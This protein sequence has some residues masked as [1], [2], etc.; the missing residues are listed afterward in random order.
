M[1]LSKAALRQEMHAR[2]EP[3]SVPERVAAATALALHADALL[4]LV[5]ASGRPVVSSYRAIGPELDPKLLEAALAVRGAQLC[6]PVMVGRSRPLL[7][8]RYADGDALVARTWGIQEPADTAAV[9]TP[10]I[11]LV[12]LLAVDG[13]G[14]RLGY[15]GGFYDRT[16]RD[17]RRN[18]RVVAVG[19]AY[20][21]QV[22]AAVP[23]EDYDE[24]LDQLLTPA[25]LRACALAG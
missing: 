6:L 1:T 4:A 10:D 19:I 25:R 14:A 13:T 11:M 17:L 2:R 8:R 12:P 22:V 18:G 5:S 23:T 15:G 24:R 20:E 3:L 9:V 21:V 16:L 7:F